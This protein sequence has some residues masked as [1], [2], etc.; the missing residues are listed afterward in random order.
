MFHPGQTGRRQ[1]HRR[2]TLLLHPTR[3]YSARHCSRPGIARADVPAPGRVPAHTP[4]DDGGKQTPAPD[5]PGPR[6]GR[7][8][9]HQPL[10]PPR[11]KDSPPRPD[12]M[13][14]SWLVFSDHG[15]NPARAQGHRHQHQY[16]PNRNTHG[17]PRHLVQ[18]TISQQRSG[19]GPRHAPPSPAVRNRRRRGPWAT[20]TDAPYTTRRAVSTRTAHTA[21]VP[22]NAVFSSPHRMRKALR[23]GP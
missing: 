7:R 21:P 20:Q 11:R 19:K 6:P 2:P 10:V 23:N 14:I 1:R 16:Y 15:S 22:M 17:G 4:P 5:P 9:F 3:Q 13:P 18:H 8:G 12:W